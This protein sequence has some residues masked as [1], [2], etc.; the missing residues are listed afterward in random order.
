MDDGKSPRILRFPEKRPDRRDVNHDRP[1]SSPNPGTDPFSEESLGRRLRGAVDSMLGDADADA[2]EA[3]A[4]WDMPV[5]PAAPDAWF[6]AGTEFISGPASPAAPA[7][8]PDTDSPAY[9]AHTAP[10]P[11]SSATPVSDPDRAAHWAR[12]RSKLGRSL[13]T[14]AGAAACFLV[15]LYFHA[16]MTGTVPGSGLFAGFWGNHPETGSAGATA[17]P[18]DSTTSDASRTGASNDPSSSSSPEEEGET[19]PDPGENDT[20]ER[21]PSRNK[22][23]RTSSTGDKTSEGD[24]DDDFDGDRDPDEDQEDDR[25]TDDDEDID[26]DRDEDRDDEE[27]RDVDDDEDRDYDEEEEEDRDEDQDHDEDRDSDHDEDRGSDQYEEEDRDDDEDS[28]SEEDENRDEE[29]E[30]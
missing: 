1:E 30:D 23:S 24:P 4:L 19:D 12:F 5:E 10:G 2:L 6:L 9:A 14:I 21:D 26:S 15:I 11:V 17:D 13:M 22:S 7:S 8:D 20:S 16:R 3:A 18:A 27:D 29:E 28:D 25:D